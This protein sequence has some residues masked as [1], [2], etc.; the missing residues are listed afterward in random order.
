MCQRRPPLRPFFP[1]F[2]SIGT[3]LHPTAL[4]CS[5]DGVPLLVNTCFHS[6]FFFPVPEFALI[7]HTI[8]V[9]PTACF[10]NNPPFTHF[11]SAYGDFPVFTLCNFEI[12]PWAAYSIGIP[13]AG[14]PFLFFSISTPV[15][16]PLTRSLSCLF[17]E[18]TSIIISLFPFGT[19]LFS[20]PEVFL[21]HLLFFL[22]FLGGTCL[23]A[24]P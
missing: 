16:R 7:L 15:E 4:P 20:P 18:V 19:L 3:H 10:G 22:N 1:L 23:L 11:F 24:P 6:E 13:V 9:F 21:P 8:S 14:S 17:F 12:V 2:R 5:R